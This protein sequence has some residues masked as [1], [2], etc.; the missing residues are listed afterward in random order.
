MNMLLTTIGFTITKN[1]KINIFLKAILFAT[2]YFKA[3]FFSLYDYNFTLKF[4]LSQLR[5]QIKVLS[6]KVITFCPI[7]STNYPKVFENDMII[8]PMAF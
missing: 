7:L 8:C 6:F 2:T 4:I 3:F 1:L 5:S